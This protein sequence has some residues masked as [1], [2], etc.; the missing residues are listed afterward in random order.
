MFVHFVNKNNLSINIK[1]GSL[2]QSNELNYRIVVISY[3][4]ICVALDL[5]SVVSFLAFEA[6]VVGISLKSKASLEN[7]Q[8][9]IRTELESLREQIK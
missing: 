5:S 3:P 4:C 1:Q 9:F 7:K 8:D 2:K 6:H